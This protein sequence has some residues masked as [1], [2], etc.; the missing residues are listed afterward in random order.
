MV[1]LGN[2]N[3]DADGFVFT[4]GINLTANLTYTVSFYIRQYR[5]NPD[6][7]GT[8][9]Y[10]FAVGTAP[11]E[12]SVTANLLSE[13]GIE[14]T[15]YVMKSVNFTP[16]ATGTYFFSLLNNSPVNDGAGDLG[17]LVDNFKVSSP[18]SVGDVLAGKFSILPNPATSLISI[19]NTE[20]INITSVS[21][22]DLNGRTVKNITANGAE[23]KV[24]VSDLATGMYMV[25]VN[26]DRGT[27]VKK[28]MKK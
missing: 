8:S 15:D 27:V 23:A 21:V 13:S 9:S 16:T 12:A 28:I 7:F 10:V 19:S 20:N 1:S 18:L 4:R 2:T 3:G 14:N 22:T 11:D 5:P 25:N 24:N 26:T 6:D 17:L